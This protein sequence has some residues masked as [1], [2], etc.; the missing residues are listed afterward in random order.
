MAPLSLFAQFK[1]DIVSFL[2]QHAG[3]VE[4][5]VVLVFG[6]LGL[7]V[8]K[9]ARGKDSFL[10]TLAHPLRWLLR[11]VG[12]RYGWERWPFSPTR[13]EIEKMHRG[14]LGGLRADAEYLRTRE[15][16]QAAEIARLGKALAEATGKLTAAHA[17]L[18]EL[19][20]PKHTRTEA[21]SIIADEMSAQRQR[22]D[23]LVRTGQTKPVPKVPSQTDLDRHAELQALA[24]AA[25]EAAE[26]HRLDCGIRDDEPEPTPVPTQAVPELMLGEEPKP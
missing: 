19:K 5:I 16:E 8:S 9:I 18:D 3:A 14:E 22:L 6:V 11:L 10:E 17:L 7:D 21:L 13:D 26:K 23:E 25:A 4:A 24:R 2:S 20:K 15:N 1:V 12:R